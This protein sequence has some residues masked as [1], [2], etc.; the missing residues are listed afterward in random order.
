MIDDK[1]NN[2]STIE[3]SLADRE[4]INSINISVDEAFLSFIISFLQASKKVVGFNANLLAQ[5]Y[6]NKNE[7]IMALD[8]KCVRDHDIIYRIY[9]PW[10][11]YGA[12][13]GA[14][15]THNYER[16]VDD[17]IDT[18]DDVIYNYNI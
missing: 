12:P 9:N 16:Q 7:C 10:V 15:N 14:K 4:D 17:A 8:N 3:V 6:T 18:I 11:A 2:A 1:I 13:L 5:P